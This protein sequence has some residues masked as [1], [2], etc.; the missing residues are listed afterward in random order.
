MSAPHRRWLTTPEAARLL[1]TSAGQVCLWLNVGRLSGKK[2]NPPRNPGVAKW[3]IDP[4]SVE[5][6][7]AKWQNLPAPSR[8]DPAVRAFLTSNSSQ[9][10]R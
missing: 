10:F 3:R 6:R 9:L 7:G 4:Q 1:N 2:I 5:K 8:A